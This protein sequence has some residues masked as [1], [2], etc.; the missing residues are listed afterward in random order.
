MWLFVLFIYQ[1]D[2]Y[3]YGITLIFF[4]KVFVFLILKGSPG[5]YQAAKRNGWLDE[6]CKHMPKRTKSPKGRPSPR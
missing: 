6:I 2:I 3:T 4:E 5:A 1:I